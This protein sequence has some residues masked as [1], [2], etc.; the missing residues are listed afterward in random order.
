MFVSHCSWIKSE[1]K[2]NHTSENV[3][4]KIVFRPLFLHVLSSNDPSYFSR[5]RKVMMISLSCAL[6]FPVNIYYLNLYTDADQ[7]SIHNINL[8]EEIKITFLNCFL[9]YHTY[10][11]L[12]SLCSMTF[13]NPEQV[14]SIFH[15]HFILWFTQGATIGE[16][17]ILFTTDVIVNVHVGLTFLN[18]HN[19]FSP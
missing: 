9:F 3:M 1:N 5:G 15:V 12:W 18:F 13:F 2:S 7:M 17:L 19:G 11:E 8:N 6:I 14:A 16:L 4:V 10:L